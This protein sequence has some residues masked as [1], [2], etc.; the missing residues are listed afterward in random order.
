[1][2][3]HLQ[4]IL[5]V[6]LSILALIRN[7]LK[8]RRASTQFSQSGERAIVFD[9]VDLL[10]PSRTFRVLAFE[11]NETQYWQSALYL[12]D[13]QVVFPI[14]RLFWVANLFCD[15]TQ[16]KILVL[17]GAGCSLPEDIGSHL[18]GAHI[19]VVEVIPGLFELASSFFITSK[20]IQLHLKDAST[21]LRESM[22][23]YNAIYVD[24]CTGPSSL[25]LLFLEMSFWEL[26]RERTSTLDGI[27]LVNLN[28]IVPLLQNMVIY[29]ITSQYSFAA[30]IHPHDATNILLVLT[31]RFYGLEGLE[32]FRKSHFSSSATMYVISKQNQP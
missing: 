26:L 31:N 8:I 24:I 30:V 3:K 27:L 6:T 11:R 17:G 16:S 22:A 4:Y 29:E 9:E 21:F 18:A 19:D 2:S 10:Q 25:P 12:Q 1:M 7:G 13:R 20:N 28:S 23:T 5:L 15:L 14:H 32:L